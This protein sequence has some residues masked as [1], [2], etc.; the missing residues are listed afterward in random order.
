MPK[1]LIFRLLLFFYC[2]LILIVG[3]YPFEFK[4]LCFS[5]KIN[6]LSDKSGIQISPCHEVASE[7][8]PTEFFKSFID[9]KGFTIEVYIA[10]DDIEQIGPARIVTYSL[11]PYQRNFTLGQENDALILRLRTS[12]SDLNGVY[13]HFRGN[14][15]FEVGRKQHITVT[16]DGK[17]EKFYVDGK[18]REIFSRL[19]GNFSNWDPKAFLVL[20][21]EYTGDRLW[22]GKIYL[23]ALYN[24]ALGDE[25]I[26]Q[27]Y[28]DVRS[29]DTA[30]IESRQNHNGLIHFYTFSEGKGDVVYNQAEPK[31]SGHLIPA[32]LRLNSLKSFNFKFSLEDI[33]F[34]FRDIVF[35]II[36]FIPLS[37]I[38]FLNAS[39]Y[40]SV[41]ASI[42]FRPI[43]VGLIISIL[44]E[45]L[46]VFSTTRVPTILDII[47]NLTGTITGSVILHFGWTLMGHKRLL[48]T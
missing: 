4:S 42:Y 8:P 29:S 31:T 41:F 12:E 7:E 23:V 44:L 25:E 17:S 6:W 15:V 24:R 35:N 38:L 22:D 13:P 46:Q 14:K 43:L 9:A 37:F 11:D 32:N 20:G 5:N 2:F 26:Y 30:V 36:G 33:S 28:I 1:R 21:N 48:K 3:L 16:Y 40:R 18:L 47:C 39:K 10:V 27:N 34:Y 45:F 19:K